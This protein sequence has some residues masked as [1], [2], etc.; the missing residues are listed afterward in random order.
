[1]KARKDI[2]ERSFRFALDVTRAIK[3]F[4]RSQEAFVISSQLIRSAT[5]ISANIAEGSAAVSRK[6]FVQFI[7]IA[8]KSAVETAHWLKFVRE[9]GLSRAQ[10]LLLKE[11]QE[12]VNILSAIILSAKRNS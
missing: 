7:A 9:L 11:A 6:E 8:R 4:P 10:D 3:G 1:M 5:S 2:E 12:I